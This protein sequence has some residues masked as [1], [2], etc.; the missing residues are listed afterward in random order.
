[1]AQERK[2]A[3]RARD[4]GASEPKAYCFVFCSYREPHVQLLLECI[5]MLFSPYYGVQLTPSALASG[6]SQREQIPKA[7]SSCTSGVVCLDGLRPNVSFE[8]GILHGQRKPVIPVA[9]GNS[10]G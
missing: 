1:M 2:P 7:I 9:R 8:Y 6:A 5:K 10:T 3:V 4:S